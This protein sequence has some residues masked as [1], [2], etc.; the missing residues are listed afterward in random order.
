LILTTIIKGRAKTAEVPQV[1]AFE[2]PGIIRPF[3]IKVRNFGRAE[4]RPSDYR[5]FV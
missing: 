5:K 3:A 4:N 2:R 1:L